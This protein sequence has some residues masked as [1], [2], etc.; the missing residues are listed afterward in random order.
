MVDMDPQE[1]RG[2]LKPTAST[3]HSEMVDFVSQ[4]V[5]DFVSNLF[6]QLLIPKCSL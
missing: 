1:V 4:E 6:A 2:R 3:A 5:C